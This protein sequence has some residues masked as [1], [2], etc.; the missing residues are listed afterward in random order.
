ME[1]RLF[2]MLANGVRAVESWL[3]P[4][5]KLLSSGKRFEVNV[6]DPRL[7]RYLYWLLKMFDLAGWQVAMHLRPWLLLNL[8]N[9]SEYIYDIRGLSLTMRS[10]TNADLAISDRPG[11]YNAIRLDTNYFSPEKGKFSLKLPFFMHPDVY[12]TGLYRALPAL[13]ER[14]DRN[15]RIFL[16]GNLASEN[17]DTPWMRERFGLMNRSEVT[18][19]AAVALQE[20]ELLQILQPEDA[21]PVLKQGQPVTGVLMRNA[22][23]PLEQWM[24]LMSRSEFFIAPPGVLMPFSH[25]IIEAMAVGT[26][27]IT[28]YGHMFDPP[29]LDE[30]TCLSFE[31]EEELRKRI[32]DA[33][34][35]SNEEIT[36]MRQNVLEYYD[37]HLD[38]KAVVGKIYERRDELERVY[39]IAGHLSIA[40]MDKRLNEKSN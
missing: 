34:N 30:E 22:I 4:S 39:L 26:I 16:G 2:E 9:C 8:R 38:A 35:M 3:A 37:T 28:Q 11:V 1:S 25:N 24:E 14:N 6:G 13:R 15:V 18:Q 5:S 32:D 29:L 10:N 33:I 21:R 17:Y 31:N 36:R 12:H 20:G 23:L 27:P 40:A 7:E 19:A